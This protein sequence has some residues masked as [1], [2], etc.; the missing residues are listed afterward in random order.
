[1]LAIRAFPRMLV[2]SRCFVCR[3][4]A[5]LASHPRL[6]P[7]RPFSTT[8]CRGKGGLRNLGRSKDV[9]DRS[10]KYLL[11]KTPAR[12]RFAPSPTG[13][14]HLG[15]LRTA[16][17]NYLLAKGTRGQFIV[18]VEDTDQVSFLAWRLVKDL[19]LTRWQ[20]RVV[21]D[22]EKRLFDDLRWANLS[23]DEGAQ[24]RL[25]T[26]KYQVLT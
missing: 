12:T 13:Y 26:Q 14:L 2:A 17:Y 6:T 18:R 19:L 22:A 16:L 15:S 21:G 10:E 24:S 7:S 8:P 25:T 23:W 9:I 5:S 1:M 3:P 20:Q 4:C 11:P